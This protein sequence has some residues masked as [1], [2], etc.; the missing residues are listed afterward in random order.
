MIMKQIVLV[1]I[2]VLQVLGS[3]GCFSSGSKAHTGESVYQNTVINYNELLPKALKSDSSVLKEVATDREQGRVQVFISELLNENKVLDARLED[4]KF[5]SFQILTPKEWQEIIV[6]YQGEHEKD[7]RVVGAGGL[8]N[9][10]TAVLVKTEE[11]WK[12]RYLDIKTS[13]T[14]NKPELIKYSVSYYLVK[15]DDTW[16]ITGMDFS[17][18]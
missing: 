15:V 6:R 7:N 5:T 8:K 14:I 16:K 4:M 3:A 1:I 2:I 17:A 18:R 12:Y 11:T 9:F 13:K 10:T